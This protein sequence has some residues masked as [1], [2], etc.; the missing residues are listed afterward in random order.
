MIPVDRLFLALLSAVWAAVRDGSEV[1]AC[2]AALSAAKAIPRGS[3]A[4]GLFRAALA[5]VNS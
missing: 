3:V 2:F 4:L 1:E 5:E